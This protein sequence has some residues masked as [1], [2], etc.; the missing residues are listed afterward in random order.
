MVREL[1][2]RLF[3]GRYGRLPYDLTQRRLAGGG[4]TAHCRQRRDV[5]EPM[6]GLLQRT[7]TG[8]C[9]PGPA[10]TS[11]WQ[12]SRLE[13]PAWWNAQGSGQPSQRLEAHVDLAAL[14]PLEETGV[15]AGFLRQ[16]FLR[17]SL[18]LAQAPDVACNGV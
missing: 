9:T 10:R 11:S 4:P 1:A 7:L 6:K 16:R 2:D 12:G 18:P 8:R 14:Y 13:K 15:E 3:L 17:E 5:R